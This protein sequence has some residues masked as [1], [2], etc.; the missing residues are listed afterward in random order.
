MRKASG[1]LITLDQH[2][3]EKSQAVESGNEERTN[4]NYNND[5]ILILKILNITN[6][7]CILTNGKFCDFLKKGI[8]IKPIS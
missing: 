6:T 1:C 8:H 2:N 3:G 4:M 7:K 5:S